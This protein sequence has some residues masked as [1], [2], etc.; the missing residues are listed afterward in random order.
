MLRIGLTGGIGSGKSTVAHLFQA[1]GIHVRDADDVSREV[2]APGT[3]GL[4][5]VIAAFGPAVVN[6]DGGL[7]RGKLRDALGDPAQRGKLERILHP[8]IRAALEDWL[9][10][11]PGPYCLLVVP[12]L[13][14]AGWRDMVDRVLVVDAP[15]EVRRRRLLQR[16][17]WTPA[18]IHEVIKAQLPRDARLCAADDVIVNDRGLAQLD[19]EVARLHEF[20]LSLAATP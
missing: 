14:E 7:D 10:L 18:Q 6:A 5:E 4:R 9:T 8:R 11:Q 20:Y 3:E 15:D 19:I 17:G 1:A 12:L 16:T 13:L 2:T